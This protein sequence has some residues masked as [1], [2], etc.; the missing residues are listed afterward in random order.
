M[1]ATAVVDKH[2]NVLSNF[3]GVFFFM[4]YTVG[5]VI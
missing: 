2:V 3:S 4:R 1:S 5:E